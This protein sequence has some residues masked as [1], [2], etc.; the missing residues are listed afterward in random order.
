MGAIERQVLQ[1]KRKNSTSCNPP[2]A[3]ET[4]DGS[5]A[6]RPGP[7][8]VA[9][10][11]AAASVGASVASGWTVRLGTTTSAV[12]WLTGVADASTGAV[13]EE[14]AAGAQAEASKIASK[15]TVKRERR[16]FFIGS[17]LEALTVHSTRK[18][19]LN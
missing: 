18:L 15:P 14:E 7:R 10:G 4:E 3:N 2:D 16:G 6:S 1:V 17:P 8:D 13:G 12:G 19:P 9:T 5:V 11:N